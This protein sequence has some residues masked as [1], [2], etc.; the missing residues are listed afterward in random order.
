MT[1]PKALPAEAER[2]LE[3]LRTLQPPLPAWSVVEE[4]L[5]LFRAALPPLIEHDPKTDKFKVNDGR[6]RLA[7]ARYG[8]LVDELPDRLLRKHK[9]QHESALLDLEKAYL[10][11]REKHEPTTQKNLW[12]KI[13]PGDKEESGRPIRKI[14]KKCGWSWTVFLRYMESEPQAP[15]LENWFNEPPPEGWE[16]GSSTESESEAST[17]VH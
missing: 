14:L 12:L 2:Q 1:K 6:R 10:K 4:H 17:L 15:K 11:C 3:W 9:K 16:P 8:K 7:I 5:A 13:A